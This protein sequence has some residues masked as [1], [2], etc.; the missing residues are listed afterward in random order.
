MAESQSPNVNLSGRVA[1]VT[2]ASTG[3][4]K[5]IAR[6][7]VRLGADVVIG[8]RDVDRGEAAKS[9]IAADAD[10]R[11]HVKQVDVAS[12]RSMRAFAQSVGEQF[13][14]VHVLVNNAGAWFSD[15]RVNADNLELT[16]ATNVLGP[17][18]L[19]GLLAGSLRAVGRSRV[20]N[21][22]SGMTARP[23]LTDLQFERRSFD[24]FQA[25]TQSKGALRMIT[26]SWAERLDGTGVTVNAAAPGF[27]RTEFNR[28]THGLRAAFINLSA[29]FFAVSPERGADT[30]L[31][32]ATAPELEKATGRYFSGRRERGSGLRDPESVA[33]LE[34]RCSELAAA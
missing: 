1:V 27:V 13:G 29:R 3:I 22:V 32:V 14:S 26:W 18:V 30:P 17:H 11:V 33:G 2:G 7:L 28:N 24:G 21:V 12:L 6:G 19:I 31:W 25:Y 4:G 20:V 34:R 9:A 16:F 15:R 10:G 5:E 23:D 8:V